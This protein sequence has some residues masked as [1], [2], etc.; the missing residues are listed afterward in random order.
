M[1][2]RCRLLCRCGL[3]SLQT[4]YDFFFPYGTARDAMTDSEQKALM[5][6]VLMVDQFLG[7]E[8]EIDSRSLR[9]GEEAIEALA[10]YG[11]VEVV[12]TR[13]GRWT[14]AGNKFR[15]KAGIRQPAQLTDAGIGLVSKPK[16]NE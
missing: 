11:L 13:F 10:T 3:A 6:L 8:R 5:A 16:L 15:E 7:N 12:G 1:D 2:R 14:E 4:A 9:A